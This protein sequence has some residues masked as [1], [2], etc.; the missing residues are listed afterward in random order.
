MEIIPVIDLKADRVV[1]ARMGQRHLYQGIETILSP[2]SDSL[3]ITAGLLSLY[4][5]STLYVADLDAI[6]GR[7]DHRAVLTQLKARHP[8]LMLWVDNGIANAD[9]AAAWLDT[10]LGCLVLGSET[11]LD[12]CVV[13]DLVAHQRVVLSLDFRGDA[14]QGPP[15]LLEQPHIWPQRVIVMTLARVGSGAGPDLERLAG[16]RRAA[17]AHKLYAAGGVRDRADLIALREAGIDGALIASALHDGR[18]VANDIAEVQRCTAA[19]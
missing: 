17:P 18:V 5:F 16:I 15:E 9:A 12:I 4:P 13:R 19:G 11:Q 14:F 6:E 7:G 8:Q 2:A 1:R 10:G 3:S